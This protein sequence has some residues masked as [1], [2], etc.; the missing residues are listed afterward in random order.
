MRSRMSQNQ[1]DNESEVVG[2]TMVARWAKIS[3]WGGDSVLIKMMAGNGASH[4]G[5]LVPGA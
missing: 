3:W 1:S 2:V 4:A 5:A